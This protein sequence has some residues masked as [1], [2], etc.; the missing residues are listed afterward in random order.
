MAIGQYMAQQLIKPGDDFRV[1]AYVLY[2][3]QRFHVSCLQYVLCF[4][5]IAKS[6]L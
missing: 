3:S 1:V 6:L 2:F 4:R 5:T